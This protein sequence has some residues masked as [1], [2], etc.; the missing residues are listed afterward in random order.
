MAEP[1]GASQLRPADRTLKGK[2]YHFCSKELARTANKRAEMILKRHQTSLT[3]Q[4]EHMVRVYKLDRLRMT[5]ELLAIEK[6]AAVCRSN[7]FNKYKYPCFWDPDV[8]SVVEFTKPVLRGHVSRAAK[9]KEAPPMLYG[10]VAYV[11]PCTRDE[12]EQ[13][14]LRRTESDSTLGSEVRDIHC[15]NLRMYRFN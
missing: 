13:E 11:A 9:A 2:L 5:K 10:E 14:G 12:E 8:D 15:F 1:L 3:K 6:S 7:N 4:S